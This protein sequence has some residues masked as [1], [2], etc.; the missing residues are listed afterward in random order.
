VQTLDEVQ[1]LLAVMDESV[2]RTNLVLESYSGDVNTQL[3]AKVHR[4]KIRF[5]WHNLWH[6]NLMQNDMTML[7]ITAHDGCVEI[8][9]ALLQSG[10]EVNKQDVSF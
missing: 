8:A 3:V 5:C 1:L 6:N 2:D 9:S 4:W 10:A 7:M